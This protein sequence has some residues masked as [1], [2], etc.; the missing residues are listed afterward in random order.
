MLDAWPG[1]SDHLP[2]YY[3][4]PDLSSDPA[5][6]LSRR[7]IYRR[8]WEYLFFLHL[9]RRSMTRLH[10]YRSVVVEEVHYCW[11]DY[12][13]SVLLLAEASLSLSKIGWSL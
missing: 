2:C 3:P 13:R 8:V 12:P 10:L 4:R 1:R 9:L 6:A 7:P 5:F 11:A